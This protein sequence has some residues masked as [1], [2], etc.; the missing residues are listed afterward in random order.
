MKDDMGLKKRNS[1]RQ[2]D[3]RKREKTV[4][5]K[6]R[7]TQMTRKISKTKCK[8]ERKGK[9]GRVGSSDLVEMDC[10]GHIERGEEK[11]GEQESELGEDM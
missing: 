6:E 4:K 1:N 7:K 2:V 11:M 10:K 3:K 8:E 5:I 9:K